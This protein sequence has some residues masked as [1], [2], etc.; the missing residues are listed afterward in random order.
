MSDCTGDELEEYLNGALGVSHFPTTPT[1]TSDP[2]VR[3]VLQTTCIVHSVVHLLKRKRR[4]C[5]LCLCF[6]LCVCA[7]D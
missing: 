1:T 5:K 2:T 7:W 4:E 6:H 3:E